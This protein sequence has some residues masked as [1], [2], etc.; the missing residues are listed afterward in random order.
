[1]ACHTAPGGQPFA[2][3]LAIKTPFGD[4]VSSNITPDPETGIGGIDGGVF[5][6]AIRD[7]IGIKGQRLYPAMPYNHYALLTDQDVADLKAYLDTV[8]A[9]RHHVD[10]NGLPFPFNIRQ[11]MAGWNLLFFHTRE[12]KPEPTQTPQWNRGNYLVNGLGHC[13]SCHTGKNL[14]GGDTL[15]F[16]RG[17][18]ADGWNAPSLANAPGIGLA[19]WS[20]QDIVDYLKTG[21][22]AHAVAAGPMDEVVRN[23]TS[24][25]AEEDL[26]AMAAYLK[27]LPGKSVENTALTMNASAMADGRQVYESHC[28]ACHTVR[29]KGL[30]S[31]ISPLA[32]NA[33]V[34]SKA[35]LTVLHAVLQGIKPVKWDPQA[36]RANMPGF[37][38]RLDDAQIAALATYIRN[39]W[40]NAAPQVSVNEVRD[41]RKAL[42]SQQSSGTAN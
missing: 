6:R 5:N 26:R 36:E 10:T 8:P 7:G 14:L 35:P 19:H 11:L 1:V 33:A 31:V 4:I 38:S 15:S 24:R 17:G 13:A 25:M 18:A 30:N 40:G 2:G 34:Q 9:V 3:G 42:A 29:G 20:D 22:N 21:S 27:S 32:G 39:S 23:S 41:A 37:A 16:L 28:A 12:F